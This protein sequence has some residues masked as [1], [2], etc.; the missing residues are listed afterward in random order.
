MTTPFETAHP[1]LRH[2]LRMR[3]PVQ[4]EKYLKIR[5]GSY[6]VYAVLFAPVT[7]RRYQFAALHLL[8]SLFK[9]SVLLPFCPLIVLKNH[10]AHPDTDLKT[11]QHLAAIT[12]LVPTP[13]TTII[14]A[15]VTY[16]NIRYRTRYR[17]S[18]VI[19]TINRAYLVKPW[20][21]IRPCISHFLVHSIVSSCTTCFAAS[22]GAYR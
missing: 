6:K 9:T 14:A 13:F 22:P 7:G 4:Y 11:H 1:L 21:E 20:Y 15:A 17:T 19:S 10:A 8:F 12:K 5:T 3:I 16:K 2:A 18:Y